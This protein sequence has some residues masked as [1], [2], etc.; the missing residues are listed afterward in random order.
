MTTVKNVL[1]KDAAGNYLIPY[2][3]NAFDSRITTLENGTEKLS[4]KNIPNGY[5]GL[6]SDGMISRSF[7]DTVNVGFKTFMTS[8]AENPPSASW[9]AIGTTI[10][11]SQYPD[12]YSDAVS[13]YNKATTVNL[14]E[15]Y[16]NITNDF[17]EKLESLDCT[18]YPLNGIYSVADSRG[19]GI[20]YNHYKT[21]TYNSSTGLY[22]LD[23]QLFTVSS[24][25]SITN[26]YLWGSKTWGCFGY[27]DDATDTAKET[28]TI[29]ETYL[30]KEQYRNNISFNI[31]NWYDS[32]N[33]LGTLTHSC[34]V[35]YTLD[36]TNWTTYY[37][38]TG[39]TFPTSAQKTGLSSIQGI[40]GVRFTTSGSGSKAG[41]SESYALYLYL[42][43]TAKLKF[44]GYSIDFTDKFVAKQL[45]ELQ[46]VNTNS[47]NDYSSIVP[48][49]IDTTLSNPLM[50]PGVFLYLYN[51]QKFLDDSY[52]LNTSSQTVTIP[53]NANYS[54]VC[55]ENSDLNLLEFYQDVITNYQKRDNS[56]NQKPYV[57]SHTQ[58]SRYACRI[59]SNNFCEQWGVVTSTG[60]SGTLTL[61]QA[62]SSST[63]WSMAYCEGFT[64]GSGSD[65]EGY[66]FTI[67]F[68]NATT[69]TVRFT[70]PNGRCFSWFAAGWIA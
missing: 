37:T 19:D 65:T 22:T 23:C 13:R 21:S 28:R 52:K 59:W 11:N 1:L 58:S 38:A 7:Y 35:E 68:T 41:T 31:T 40:K 6:G 8:N 26:K 61:P 39:S 5:V 17:I 64:T 16:K 24:N 54:Y 33:A 50:S 69:N 48:F 49:Q 46:F 3:S 56:N 20:S 57:V 34:S 10:S 42:Y 2:P 4:N 29:T 12:F 27:R 14:A 15:Q 43:V 9:K 70:C 63:A 44:S 47:I 55:V 36:G 53:T 67:G 45:N 62:Y 18:L 66:D 32:A 51:Y 60:K 25:K 30:I